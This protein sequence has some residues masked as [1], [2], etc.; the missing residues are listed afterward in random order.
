MIAKL[1]LIC[2]AVVRATDGSSDSEMFNPINVYTRFIDSLTRGAMTQNDLMQ[3]DS[4]QECEIDTNVTDTVL[5]ASI[6]ATNA[7]TDSLLKLTRL[8]R[9]ANVFLS[10]TEM[11]ALKQCSMDSVDTIGRF[12]RVRPLN[13]EHRQTIR[14]CAESGTAYNDHSAAAALILE[15]YS[16][17]V[18][19]IAELQQYFDDNVFG[20]DAEMDQDLVKGSL[21]Q[22]CTNLD[23]YEE[24]LDVASNYFKHM[25]HANI[26]TWG[27][28]RRRNN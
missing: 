10:S 3:L 25:M 17:C 28:S 26:R 5:D 22:T 1:L 27:A 19:D 8:N 20:E 14:A 24:S 2:A 11:D 4:F 13:A 9:V 16:P 21:E 12:A 15:R 23:T 18:T 6:S 7:C